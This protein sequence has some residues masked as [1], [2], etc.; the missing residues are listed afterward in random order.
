MFDHHKTLLMKFLIKLCKQGASGF[1]KLRP[2]ILGTL[3]LLLIGLLACSKQA[4]EK[5]L[6]LDPRYA[7]IKSLSAFA[8]CIGPHGDYTTEVE[9]FADGSC[10]FTQKYSYS[11]SSF[12]SKLT[13]DNQG[14]ILDSLNKV[15]DTLS[16]EEIEIVRSHEFHKLHTRPEH[17]FKHITYQKNIDSNLELF[18]ARDRL[19]NPV[20]LYY[21]KTRQLLYKTELRNPVDTTEQIEIV[22]QAWIDSEYGKM[23]KEIEIIQGGKDTFYFDFQY[24]DINQ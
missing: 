6:I 20:S 5:E 8:K 3:T 18:V 15:I 2:G 19:N 11:A 1:R 4:R 21:D 22:N 24:I 13:A 12:Y 9:S 23:I 16:R 7:G 14:Y 17:F 10:Y